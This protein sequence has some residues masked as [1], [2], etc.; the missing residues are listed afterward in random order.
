MNRSLI[1]AVVIFLG[2]ASTRTLKETDH[3]PSVLVQNGSTDE[4][5]VYV[6]TE[7]GH[8]QRVGRV[9]GLQSERVSIPRVYLSGAPV[10]LA[11][12]LN[13]GTVLVADET[14]NVNRS[15]YAIS[16]GNNLLYVVPQ[17]D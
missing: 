16:S 7:S 17:G 12:R 3:R 4:V 11:V 14:L 10:R 15:V 8:A 5:T 13:S 9:M 2:C 1:L 6:L